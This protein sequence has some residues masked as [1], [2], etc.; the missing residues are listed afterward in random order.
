MINNPNTSSELRD[1]AYRQIGSSVGSIDVNHPEQ[2]P[3]VNQYSNQDTHSDKEYGSIGERFKGEY[4]SLKNPIA[5][6]VRDLYTA[7]FLFKHGLIGVTKNEEIAQGLYNRANVPEHFTQAGLE[8]IQ[9][10]NYDT[11][12]LQLANA[13]QLEQTNAAVPAG[14]LLELGLVKADRDPMELY[15]EA[16]DSDAYANYRMGEIASFDQDD[17]E[18]A[19]T[20]YKKAAEGGNWDAMAR[21][22]GILPEDETEGFKSDMNSRRDL[23]RNN[24]SEALVAQDQGK[25]D[26]VT[27]FTTHGLFSLL[28]GKDLLSNAVELAMEEI[29]E[30]D[31]DIQSIL[32]N[33]PIEDQDIL[34][35]LLTLIDAMDTK[36]TRLIAMNSGI[37]TVLPTDDISEEQRTLLQ[38]IRDNAHPMK[39]IP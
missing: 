26:V 31:T 10:G 2:H 18:L 25:L 36:D 34:S 1:E 13:L 17:E 19:I 22:T 37:E 5:Q 12:Y 24:L 30:E 23:F 28:D 38:K 27:A 7:G 8:N 3:I 9:R 35:G 15:A 39:Q 20:Y 11:A 14:R 33:L 32:L 6:E 16:E 21:L 29:Q 4:Q